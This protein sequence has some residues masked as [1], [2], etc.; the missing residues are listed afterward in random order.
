MCAGALAKMQEVKK[1]R[2]VEPG[3]WGGRLEMK[4]AGPLKTSVHNPPCL[5]LGEK[6]FLLHCWK[7]V[8]LAGSLPYLH[9]LAHGEP[10]V[11]I[12]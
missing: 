5:L 1:G 10:S 6:Y 2:G 12:Y 4:R 9:V 7:L 11:N 3:A 8:T